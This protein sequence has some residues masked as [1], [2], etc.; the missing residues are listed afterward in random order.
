MAPGNGTLEWNWIDD[1]RALVVPV[2][3]INIVLDEFDG[4]KG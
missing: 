1:N 4:A 3:L 2:W